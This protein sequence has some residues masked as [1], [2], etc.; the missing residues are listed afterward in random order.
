MKRHIKIMFNL[1]FTFGIAY[2]IFWFIWFMIK[3]ISKNNSI[4]FCIAVLTF[5]IVSIISCR[6]LG[7][8]NE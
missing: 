3:G 7:I 1:W 5:F 6:L 8:R 4:W 2:I